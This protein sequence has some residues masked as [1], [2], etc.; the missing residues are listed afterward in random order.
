[1]EALFRAYLGTPPLSIADSKMEYMFRPNQKLHR[2][3]NLLQFN[4]Y[5]MRSSEIRTDR[6]F[7]VLVVG[8][9]VV[10][11]GNLTDQSEL[12]TDIL[13]H[14]RTGE[15]LPI[16]ALNISAGSWGP[17]NALAYLRKFGTFN[18]DAAILV[19][20]SHDLHDDRTFAPLD[21]ATHPTTAP[22]SATVEFINR[23]LQRYSPVKW[24]T[25]PNAGIPVQDDAQNSLPI[26]FTTLR[27]LPKGACIVFHYERG[28]RFAIPDEFVEISELAQL[29]GLPIVH[30]RGYQ[31]DDAYRDEIHPNAKGQLALLLAMKDCEV[32]RAQRVVH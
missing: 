20:S 1:M 9:S 28:Q 2:F 8:D 31:S 30:D 4:A 13:S 25:P 23:Y 15:G 27:Q 19:L 6:T 18:A 10:N 22:P 29:Y 16:E 32:L 11:G 7:R 12:A 3:G 5:G 14:M 21:P 17:G 26:L 24:T